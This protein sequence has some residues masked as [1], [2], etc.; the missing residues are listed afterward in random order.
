MFLLKKIRIE[1]HQNIVLD[2]TFL[3]NK[4]NEQPFSTLILGENGTGK[5]FLL[6]TIADIFIFLDKMQTSKRKP[7]FRYDRF[8]VEYY[9]DEHEYEINR[10]SG[11]EILCKYDG[12]D[13]DFHNIKLPSSVLAVAFMVNDKFLFVDEHKQEDNIYKYLG[14]RKTSN[15]TYTSSV[16]DRVIECV[17]QIIKDGLLKEMSTVLSVLHFDQIMDISFTNVSDKK[18]MIVKQIKVDCSDSENNPFEKEQIGHDKICHLLKR[19][20]IIPFQ[21]FFYKNGEKIDFESCSSGE[22]HMI[23]ALSGIMNNINQNSLILID[24]P[25][26]SLHPEWQ[27]RYISLLKKVFENYSGCHF[28]L[29]SHSH[30][31]VSDLKEETSSIVVLTKVNEKAPHAELLPY[32]TYAWSAENIIY[33]I[34]GLRTTR[35]YY[36]ESDLHKLLVGMQAN[37]LTEKELNRLRELI[38]KLKKYIYNDEDPLALI[39][40]QAEGFLNVYTKT[41]SNQ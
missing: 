31:L 6:K 13:I 21:I 15:A 17:T 30:Y 40:R 26:I 20:I 4:K 12:I 41:S 39:I 10:N 37:E 27:I 9:I 11:S 38:T 16:C 22:K 19:N 35:N 14:V 24:E 18:K 28:I 23:F 32:S 36:F 7:R 5:S 25:E 29:A 1:N 8:C 2:V 33:N 3:N 34:F